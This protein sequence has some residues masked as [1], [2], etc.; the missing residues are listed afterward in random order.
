MYNQHIS[1]LNRFTLVS[2]MSVVDKIESLQD[3]VITMTGEH[4]KDLSPGYEKNTFP[5]KVLYSVY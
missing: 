1:S 2:Y 3:S 5:Q 4:E